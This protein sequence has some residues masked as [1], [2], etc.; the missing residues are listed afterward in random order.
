MRAGAI[1]TVGAAER[2]VRAARSAGRHDACGPYR[3]D[4]I[5]TDV[6]DVVQSAGG[7]L[8]DR[9][10]AGWEVNVLMP[11]GGDRRALQILGVR[12]VD[13]ATALSAGGTGLAVSAGAYAAE[14]CVRE[15]LQ[16]ALDHRLTE[17][18]VWGEGWPAR[19]DGVTT[20]VRY[21]L[22]AAAR[23]FKGQ[24]LAAAGIAAGPTEAAEIFRSDLG[25]HL[26][27]A[28]DLLPFAGRKRV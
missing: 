26:P 13:L 17:V 21:P 22:S 25:T 16:A 24:A 7:W 1:E 5:G 12:T 9:V 14:G 8:Y 10:M 15:A 19:I 4:V 20:A 23:V 18:T 28:S 6:A 27:V 3:L 2:V 11:R